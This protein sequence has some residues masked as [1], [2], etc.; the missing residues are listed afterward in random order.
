VK[1]VSPGPQPPKVAITR[2]NVS[3]VNSA[4]TM[5]SLSVQIGVGTFVKESTTI[6]VIASHVDIEFRQNKEHQRLQFQFSIFNGPIS[7][8]SPGKPGF[9]L[10]P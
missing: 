9:R 3:P 4:P 5:L 2:I 6:S 8:W 10:F 1:A 7:S